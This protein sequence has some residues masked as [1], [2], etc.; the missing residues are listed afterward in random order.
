MEEV[1]QAA[2]QI[3]A[4]GEPVVVVSWAARSS[5]SDQGCL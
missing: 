4:K 3:I 1:N 2:K 5:F